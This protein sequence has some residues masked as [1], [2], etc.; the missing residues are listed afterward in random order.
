MIVMMP[1]VEVLIFLSSSVF[2][3]ASSENKLG[4]LPIFVYL[5]IRL[6]VSLVVGLYVYA[7]ERLLCRRSLF[8]SALFE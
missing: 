8:N 6:V 2:A 5:T 1:P 4:P 3:N 7:A